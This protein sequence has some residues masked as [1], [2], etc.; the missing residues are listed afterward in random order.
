MPEA[1]IPG[2][3]SIEEQPIENKPADVISQPQ[4]VATDI[5]NQELLNVQS[6]KKEEQELPSVANESA[7]E[8]ATEPII[9]TDYDYQYDPV[10]PNATP[11]VSKVDFKEIINLIRSC[12]DQIEKNGYKIEVEEYDLA[13]LYQVVF[14]IDKQ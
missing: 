11:Q 8:P 12:S 4:G 13:N 5:F 14:K 2:I 3:N 6:E 10:M 7:F 9:T 1:P